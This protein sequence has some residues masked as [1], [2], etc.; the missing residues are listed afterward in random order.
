[1]VRHQTVLFLWGLVLVIVGVNA[2]DRVAFVGGA[3]LV[4]AWSTVGH[5]EAWFE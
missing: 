2:G 1:M 4:D 3:A 5:Q